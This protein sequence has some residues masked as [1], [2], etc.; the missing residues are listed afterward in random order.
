MATKPS[1]GKKTA[2]AKKPATKKA[3]KQTAA[4][5]AAKKSTAKKPA[6]KSAAKKTT[7]KPAANKTTTK[8]PKVDPLREVAWDVHCAF[9][10]ED[11]TPAVQIEFVE[12]YL[13]T[14]KD[15]GIAVDFD[16]A[17]LYCAEVL[18]L[19]ES[20]LRATCEGHARKLAAVRG[21]ASPAGELDALI[22]LCSDEGRNGESF[23]EH[24]ARAVRDAW[25]RLGPEL[26]RRLLAER[27][28][29]RLRN[30]GPFAT[31]VG[32]EAA[33]DV[34]WL[35]LEVTPDCDLTPLAS[36]TRLATL[37][38]VGKLDGFAV[39]ARLPKLTTLHTQAN[40]AGIA[41]LASFPILRV[42]DLVVA[43]D[44][45]IAGL[46]DLQHLNFL[47]LQAGLR[48]LDDVTAA[49]IAALARKKSRL[50]RLAEHEGWPLQLTLPYRRTPGYVDLNFR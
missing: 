8:R 12:G 37:R 28:D 36:L 24:G 50:L 38:L 14:A 19:E 9:D 15:R 48:S 23:E 3:T 34:R 21:A 44:V 7:K 18:D 5:K 17:L 45:S 11:A 35:E 26:G 32:F 49:T 43:A 10:A 46:L 47:I 33:R 42:L 6:T 40:A 25:P 30:A 22:A 27:Q 29:L 39:L 16:T 20:A 1:T 41:E 13:E 31:L 4:K 2:A